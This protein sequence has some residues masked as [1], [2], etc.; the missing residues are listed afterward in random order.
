MPTRKKIFLSIIFALLFF[1][2]QTS[3]TSAVDK[4]PIGSPC[5]GPVSGN[6]ECRSNDCEGSQ[7]KDASGKTLSFCDCVTANDCNI[8]YGTPTTGKWECSDGAAYTYNSDY[9]Y[10]A[11]TREVKTASGINKNATPISKL[12]DAIFD[13]PATQAALLEK[14]KTFTPNLEITIPGVEFSNLA[15]TTD[16]EG[17]LNI[18]WIGEYIVGVYTYALGIAAI[19]AAIMIIIAGVRWTTSGG[20]SEAIGSS[21]KRIGG[22]LV[23][24]L[25]AYLSYAVLNIINPG[26]TTFKSL[27]VKYIEPLELAQFIAESAASADAE[28]TSGNTVPGYPPGMSGATP[29]GRL[30]AESKEEAKKIGGNLKQDYC[31]VKNPSA[32]L[33]DLQSFMSGRGIKVD[34]QFYGV[35]DC[36][37]SDKPRPIEQIDRVVLHCGF[38]QNN[39]NTGTS[40]VKNMM[41][42]WRT[43]SMWANPPTKPVPICSHFTIDRE[44]TLFPTADPLYNCAHAPSQN[45]RSVGVDLLYSP[46]DEKKIFWTEAQYKTTG[47]LIEYLKNK[48]PKIQAADYNIMGHGECQDNRT[49]P[50][51]FLFEKLKP[52]VS[53]GSFNNSKHNRLYVSTELKGTSDPLKFSETCEYVKIGDGVQKQVK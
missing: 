29:G 37:K 43:N 23:G 21:K 42:M 33:T 46:T 47:A 24:L 18:P 50:Q 8:E 7:K 27:K 30:Q 12:T 32:P 9:C 16:E 6:S 31:E 5:S 25:I 14:V 52:Y 45:K 49:D 35:L 38:A 44:G 48:Y 51:N 1:V 26:L 17:Y 19:I 40:L 15:D 13:S 4:L 11:T 53:G 34:N 41:A 28:L 39:A 2:L 36:N 22:A 3:T 10:N 20:N